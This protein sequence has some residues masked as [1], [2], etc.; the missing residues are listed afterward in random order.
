MIFWGT[1][2]PLIAEAVTGTRSSLGS[3]WFDRYVTPIGVLLVLFTGIGPLLAWG[4]LSRGSAAAAAALAGRRRGA[5]AVVLA[6]ASDAADSPWALFLF[7]FAAFTA[8]GARPGV[9]AG[10]RGPAGV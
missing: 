1:F 8:G 2:F 4:R 3:P 10:G 9:L 7:S 5:T 6:L